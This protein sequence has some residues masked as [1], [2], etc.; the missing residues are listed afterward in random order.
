MKVVSPVNNRK[1]AFIVCGVCEAPTEA[2]VWLR[3][4]VNTAF[5]SQ[6]IVIEN[7]IMES[8]KSVVSGERLSTVYSAHISFNSE[9]IL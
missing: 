8:I 1:L 4:N 5:F 3:T 7:T 2:E 9:Y 6:R